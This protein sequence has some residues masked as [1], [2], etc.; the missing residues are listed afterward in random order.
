MSIC[1]RRWEEHSLKPSP[2][3]RW[4]LSV[5]VLL[6]A[7]I[8]VSQQPPASSEAPES[9]QVPATGPG[10]EASSQARKPRRKGGALR[11]MVG[12]S[13]LSTPRSG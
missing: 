9:V 1:S 5:L 7:S 8:A 3:V 4:V 10:P 12:K 11:V 13:L 2:R 6:T